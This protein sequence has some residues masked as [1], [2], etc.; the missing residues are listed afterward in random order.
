MID[1]RDVGASAA[2]VLSSAGHEGQTYLL[3]GP[4]AIT[5]AQ[6]AAELSEVMG[7]RVEFIDIP[8]DAAQQA[9]IR[10]GLPG[11]VAE[12]IIKT[13][14]QLRQGAGAQV[15]PTVETLTGSAPRDFASFARAHARLFAPATA[16]AQ[17]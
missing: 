13:L 4:A 17:R 14:A 8:D 9:M 3:T 15:T 12:Q 2:A 6:V 11:F 1:P 7:S 16:T 10:D 5:Y